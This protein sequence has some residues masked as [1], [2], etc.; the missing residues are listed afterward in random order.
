MVYLHVF[1]E[2]PTYLPINLLS[3]VH[4]YKNEKLTVPD[5]STP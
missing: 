1:V 2:V 5:S 4:T 3:T